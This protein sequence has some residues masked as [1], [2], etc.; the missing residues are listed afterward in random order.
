MFDRVA[1]IGLVAFVVATLSCES[2]PPPLE[3]AKHLASGMDGLT[4]I[5]KRKACENLSKVEFDYDSLDESLPIVQL[6]AAAF[7]DSAWDKDVLEFHCDRYWKRP[8]SDIVTRH[9]SDIARPS[10]IR[11]CREWLDYSTYDSWKTF[12]D[13]LRADSTELSSKERS[14]LILSGVNF[15]YTTEIYFEFDKNESKIRRFCES[16]YDLSED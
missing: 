8:I 9:F 11:S 6:K 7:L 14:R 4:A 2:E 16:A 15:N 1:L 5:Q 12:R 10:I 3:E 13:S